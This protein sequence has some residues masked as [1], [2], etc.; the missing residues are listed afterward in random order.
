MLPSA[1]L[2]PQRTL[3]FNLYCNRINIRNCAQA[4]RRQRRRPDTH[5]HIHHQDQHTET[6]TIY[7]IIS[8]FHRTQPKQA[9]K[10]RKWCTSAG[11]Q[12]FKPSSSSQPT[13]LR[14]WRPVRQ[15]LRA[16]KKLHR[17]EQPKRDQ[18][19]NSNER[20][21]AAAAREP[22]QCKPQQQQPSITT[23]SAP[24]TTTTA[25]SSNS[26]PRSD[27]ACPILF[28]VVKDA[29]PSRL[30][31]RSGGT[32]TLSSSRARCSRRLCKR[33]TLKLKL[34]PPKMEP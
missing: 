10:Y 28:L 6:T 30:C 8:Y 34:L 2:P 21:Q 22:S 4:G 16:R 5:K 3:A 12:Q 23:L 13:K 27:P 24:T 14:H 9:P 11:N 32:G 7:F 33:P 26:K 17:E 31:P 25:S 19:A 1:P 18:S 15:Q 20:E 29:A